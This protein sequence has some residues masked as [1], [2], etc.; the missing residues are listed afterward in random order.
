MLSNN[1]SYT[2]SIW[3][4]STETNASGQVYNNSIFS[5]HNSS[6]GNIFRIG[7][8]PD[9]S[10]GVYYNI[11]SA[12]SRRTSSTGTNLQMSG[13][14]IFISKDTGA[15]AQFYLDNNLVSTNNSNTDGTPF[16]NVGKV[17]IGQ[18]FDNASTSDHFQGSIPV[19][20]IYNNST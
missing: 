9:A 5:M 11:G 18:E 20:I 2:I 8:A 7:A 15:Q 12:D 6:G 4:K 14:N 13:G 16:N 17:S 1:S 10:K 3:F 19:V